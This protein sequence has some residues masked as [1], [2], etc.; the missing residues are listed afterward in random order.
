MGSIQ[1]IP[2]ERR[3]KKNVEK[4]KRNKM[5]LSSS[6]KSNVLCCATAIANEEPHSTGWNFSREMSD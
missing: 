2:K 6:M 3:E 1:S 5:A 4:I